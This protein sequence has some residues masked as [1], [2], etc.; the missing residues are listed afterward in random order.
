MREVLMVDVEESGRRIVVW[1]EG[2]F[3]ILRGRGGEGQGLSLGLRLAERE[4]I[5]SN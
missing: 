2:D 3:L 1:I 5:I 4:W